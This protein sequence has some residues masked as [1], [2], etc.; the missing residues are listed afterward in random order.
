MKCKH[1]AEYEGICTNGDCFYRADLCPV[2]EHQE[3]C[4]H[5]QAVKKKVPPEQYQISDT[6]LLQECEKHGIDIDDLIT[7]FE[8]LVKDCF[9]NQFG[10][11]L[12][13][14]EVKKTDYYTIIFLKRALTLK[15]L[16][17]YKKEHNAVKQWQETMRERVRDDK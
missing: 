7:D 4:R 14:E 6:E 5:F 8:K 15:I 11:E 3:T 13:L 2:E 1:Y 17:E 16:K 9:F 10:N 12:T